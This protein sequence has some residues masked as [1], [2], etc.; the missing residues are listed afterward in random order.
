MMG[1]LGG[2][3]WRTSLHRLLLQLQPSTA[4]AVAWRMSATFIATTTVRT[5]REMDYRCCN[6][7][8]KCTKTRLNGA[9]VFE[10]APK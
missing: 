1:L 9:L 4:F 7:A 6:A 8:F 3:L 5:E 10:S 2:G